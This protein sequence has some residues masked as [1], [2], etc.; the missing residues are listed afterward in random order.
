LP[1]RKSP[2]PGNHDIW[3]RPTLPATRC[4]RYEEDLPR[5]A[6]DHGFHYLD[7]GPLFYLKPTWPWS[8]RS[9]GT[10]IPGLSSRFAGLFPEEE[11]RLAS[12]RFTRGRHNDA[13]FVRW[14]LNDAAFT[15]RVVMDFWSGT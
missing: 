3:S 12:K 6:A 4:N 7:Q 8:A 1:C 13:N 10:T 9:T 14:G 11:P 5:L 15:A 2:D